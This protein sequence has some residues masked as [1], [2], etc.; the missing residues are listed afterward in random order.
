MFDSRG[1][2]DKCETENWA[3]KYCEYNVCVGV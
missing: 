1:G 3:G 2:N